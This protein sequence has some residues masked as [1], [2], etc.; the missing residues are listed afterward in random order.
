MVALTIVCVTMGLHIYDT[1]TAFLVV[2]GI[3]NFLQGNITNVFCL[4]LSAS[5]KSLEE[6]PLGIKVLEIL[7]STEVK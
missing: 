7:K 3:P 5:F 4:K 1:Y 6:P 2:N